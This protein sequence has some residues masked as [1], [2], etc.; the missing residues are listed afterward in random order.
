LGDFARSRG[1]RFGSV[2][3]GQLEGI[4]SDIVAT[5]VSGRTEYWLSETPLSASLSVF[6]ESDRDPTQAVFVPRNRQDGFDYVAQDNSIAFYGDYRP[7]PSEGEI[8][9]DFVA[10]RFEYFVDRCLETEQGADNCQPEE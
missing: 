8:A 1:G 6:V 3:P 10:A 7:E 2:C 9:E 4:L 5:G